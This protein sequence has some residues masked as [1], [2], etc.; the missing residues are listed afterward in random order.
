MSS[1]IASPYLENAVV[2]AYT[3]S[4]PLLLTGEPGC[5]KTQC[6]SWIKETRY[7]EVFQH[8]YTFNVKTT[9]SARDLFYRYDAIQHFRAAQKQKK[10]EAV[11]ILDYIHFTALG[12][13]ILAASS[14]QRCVVL[15]QTP[16]YLA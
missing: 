13:A 15:K 5:G 6:A 9:S 16:Q 11:N 3:M 4:K 8:L 10:G 7:V 1:Y 12:L 2:V 14:G